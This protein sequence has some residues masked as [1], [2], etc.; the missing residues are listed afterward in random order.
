MK[1]FWTSK[2]LQ[3]KEQYISESQWPS[4]F[5]NNKF[6]FN[7]SHQLYILIQQDAFMNILQLE[8]KFIQ[9]YNKV[10]K[11]QNPSN[12]IIKFLS[13][14]LIQGIWD[15]PQ[16]LQA[17]CISTSLFA[18]FSVQNTLLWQQLSKKSVK[19]QEGKSAATYR[20]RRCSVIHSWN[21]HARA[22]IPGLEC[23]RIP[24]TKAASLLWE[25]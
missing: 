18:R 8:C 15:G 13:E 7:V 19:C 3:C 10:I 21:G 23:V 17:L 14:P 6:K 20:Q 22:G 1:I 11:L 12:K 2:S 4:I 5:I 16:L 9:G 25:I 24:L